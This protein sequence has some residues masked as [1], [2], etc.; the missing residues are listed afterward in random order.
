MVEEKCDVT[1]WQRSVIPGL[2]KLLPCLDE[3]RFE[4]TL[5][6]H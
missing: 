5:T 1:R 3:V 2:A 6:T 4:E